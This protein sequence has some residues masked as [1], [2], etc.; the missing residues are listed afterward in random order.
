MASLMRPGR[1][2]FLQ[3]AAAALLTSAAGLPT[4]ADTKRRIPVIFDTDI[5][6]DIDDT[7]ALLMLLRMPQFDVRL[8]AG[9]YG[10]AIYRA[11]LLA[12]I[13]AETGNTHIP[14]GIG[15]DRRDEPSYQS[16]WLGDY[17]LAD[18]SGV[19]HDDGVQRIIDIVMAAEEPVTLLCVGPV[20]NIAA[21]LQR[22]PA[23]AENATF[24][25]MHGS[26]RVGYGGSPEPEAEWNVRADPQSL[27]AVFAA[28]WEIT[29]TPLDTCG[30]IVLEGA[31]QRQISGSDDPWMQLLMANYRAWL[32]NPP[33][34]DP[35][36]DPETTSS[37][38]FDTVAV[39]LAAGDEFLEVEELPLRV[40]DDGF[41]VI[42][43]VNGRPT[44]CA[45]AWRDQQA[46][47]RR[48]VEILLG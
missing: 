26:V 34:F 4:F 25:G 10:N 47:E 16:D 18:Y 7:W 28:P 32:P 27:Q 24:V 3:S 40:T 13:L 9:D 2:A 35:N 20:P 48:L 23:I 33:Y 8:I 11:R 14:I 6:D 5:G 12:K 37:T 44:R 19:V 46:F 45:T 22:E 30:L 42:D 31:A 36:T 17:R 39:H 21:A 41:T 43:S 29:I 1:R 38:L 15:V